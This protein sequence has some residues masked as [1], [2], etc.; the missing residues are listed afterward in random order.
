VV[1]NDL[2]RQNYKVT[3]LSRRPA[4]V[5][6]NV[7]SVLGE[8]RDLANL[9]DVAEFDTILLFGGMCGRGTCFVLFFFFFSY[10]NFIIGIN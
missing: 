10:R 9:V 1:V 7:T 4:V 2:A 5:S 3:V 6:A 8:W